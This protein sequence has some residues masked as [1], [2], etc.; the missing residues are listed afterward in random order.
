VSPLGPVGPVSPLGP[1][2]PVFPIFPVLE[3]CKTNSSLSAG[4]FEEET[5]VAGIVL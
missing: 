3:K 4:T 2:G 5:L 1:V